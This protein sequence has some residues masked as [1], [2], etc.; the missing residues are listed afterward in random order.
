[1]YISSQVRENIS[2]FQELLHC[3]YN[4]DVVYR[5]IEI[6]GKEAC[7]FF[8]DG[9]AQ[10]QLIQKLMEA[11]YNVTEPKDLADAHA[12]SKRCVPYCEVGLE[13]EISKVV[14]AILSGQLVLFVDGFEQCITIDTRTYPQRETAEPDKDKVFRGSKD[15]FVETMVF[16]AALLRRRIRDSHFCVEYHQVGRRSKTDI[17]IC[18][19]SDLVDVEL[20]N[21]IRYKIDNANVQALT[22]N[23]ESLAE[24]LIKKKWYNPFPKFKYTERPDT[25]AAQILEGDIVILVDNSP[26]AMLLPTN[27]FDVMEEANDY[28]FPPIT[29]SYLRLTRFLVT[30]LTLLL[31]PTWLLFL[32]MPQK[33]PQ[34]LSFIL[35]DEP[36]NIPI[37]AQLLILELAIDGLKLA[38]LNT[39]NMLTTSLSMIGA[40]VVG[41]FA[42]QSG[43]FVPE[44]MLY[45]AF[46]AIANY[47][48]PCYELG[49]ALKF[50]RI[51]LLVT[52]AAAG[53]WGYWGGLLLIFFILV[54][55]K[56]VS[57]Q[58]YLYP[59]IP[60]HY[61]DLKKKLLRIKIDNENV[62]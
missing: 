42:V 2:G 54:C 25:C 49:Y 9:F 13:R 48:Q 15:G 52:T 26:S 18:Y 56:T 5:V 59:L 8:I 3:S 38:T 36:V 23:Q 33:I 35:V 43:W 30:M 6:G 16:N 21:K 20:L 57:G 50:M 41:D 24:V 55:N 27:F 44:A 60:F 32:Q 17:A 61:W 19:I 11:F 53:I 46:V 31:T 62:H 10:G 4:F 39:P 47:S 28:Y 45:M 14:E 29:G 51:L 58:C 22:M 7:L 40:I 34:W 1:M 37:L 12:F